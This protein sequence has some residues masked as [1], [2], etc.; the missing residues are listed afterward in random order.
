MNAFLWLELLTLLAKHTS[1]L[2]RGASLKVPRQCFNTPRRGSQNEW[3]RDALYRAELG[4]AS[5]ERCICDSRTA[6]FKRFGSR[7]QMKHHRGFEQF[8]KQVLGVNRG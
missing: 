6:Q 5:L 1:S 2:T 4:V 3:L 7:S 8:V